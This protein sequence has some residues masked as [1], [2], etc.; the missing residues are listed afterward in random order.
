MARLRSSRTGA[1]LTG[2]LLALAASG[3]FAQGQ[4]Q[5][6]YLEVSIDGKPTGAVAPFRQLPD[7]QLVAEVG[8][9]REAGLD[10]ARLGIDGRP[11][12]VLGEVPGLRFS[13]DQARQSVDLGLETSLRAPTVLQARRTPGAQPGSVTT[14]AVLNY[15]LYAR[16]GAQRGLS[17]L[18]QARWFGAHGVLVSSGHASLHDARRRYVRHDTTWTRSDPDTLSTLQVGDLVT[19]SLNWS[20]AYRMAGVEW[21]KNFELRPDLLTFPVAAIAGSAVVPSNVSLYV[22]GMQQMARQVEG[23][24]FV[25]DG[26]AGLNGAGQATLVTQDA[27]GRSVSRTVPLYVDTR[28]LAPGLSDFALS[29]GVLRRDYGIASFRYAGTPVGTASLRHG[30]SDW[31]TL[32]AHAEAGRGLANAGAGGLL[33]L[34]MAGVLSGA[35]AASTG[36]YRGL[37]AQL[38]Y[39]YVSQRFAFDLQSTRASRGYGDLGSLEGQAVSR[40]GDR[41]SLSGALPLLGS[42][43]ASY[44]RYESPGVGPARLASLAW[45]RALGFGFY[46]SLNAWQDLD[47]RAARGMMAS[48][49]MALGSRI[50]ASASGGRQNGEAGRVATL[51]RAPDFEGG[52]GWALQSGGSGAQRFSGAQLQYLGARG[53]LNA[54]LQRNAGSGS[55]ALGLSGALVAMNGTLLAARQVGNAFALV[56]TGL[57]DVPVLQENRPIGRTDGGGHILLPNLIPYSANLIAIDTAGLPADMRV[58]ATSARVAPQALSGVLAAFPMERYRAATV[59]LHDASGQPIAPGTRVAVVGSRS[60]TIVG[61]D[62]IVFV[63]GLSGTTRLRVGDDAGA[64]E[65]EF[66]YQA[67]A[68]GGLPT[69]GPLR[70]LPLKESTR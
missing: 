33:R 67:D 3:G 55:G 4:A 36:R 41:A 12:V 8:A 14:G 61:F 57:A 69:I 46:L 60:A 52:F 25:V 22:N 28:L 2:L 62:G 51:T 7:G 47:R 48:L 63:D 54:G 66:A 42:L 17:V 53:M 56:S 30:L 24:P 50:S 11:E 6:L 65:A 38:G 18:H 64:C 21:R 13:F 49:S 44:I 5:Q 68:P 58:R 35:V 31:L 1:R 29:A 43:S 32:E 40:A 10:T 15:D 20:R 16:F 19:P 9:L 70:C 45:S 34:G 39:Q 26:I 27:L 23:G 37:Q 59:I